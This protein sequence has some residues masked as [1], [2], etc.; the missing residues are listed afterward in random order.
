VEERPV[1][2]LISVYDKRDL[3]HLARGLGEI[4]AEIIATLEGTNYRLD[5]VNG[6]TLLIKGALV[7]FALAL[8]LG[9]RMLALRANPGIRTR[10]LR[11]LT[12]WELAA[13]VAVLVAVGVLVNSAP[14][15]SSAQV[16]SSSLT[17]GPAPLS[18]PTLQLGGLFGLG[19]IVGVSASSDELRFTILKIDE[20]APRGTR[21]R[22]EVLAPRSAELFPRPCGAGGFQIHYPLSPCPVPLVVSVAVPHWPSELRPA[23]GIAGTGG[24]F[25]KPEDFSVT[26]L[27][28]ANH[29]QADAGARAE[30]GRRSDE[31]RQR[32]LGIDRAA[33]VEHHPFLA[34]R[35]AV[36][37]MSATAHALAG[38]GVG[39]GDTVISWLPNGPQALR[40]WFGCGQLGAVFVPVNT[41]YKGRLE[42]HGMR[43]IA[44]G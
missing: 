14:P 37:A 31:G 27:D 28:R 10:L 7:A 11:R 44:E 17:L 42:Q 29:G 19:N 20:P 40:T 25:L 26:A 22:V 21:M 2:V 34:H 32:S 4:G 6:R 36:D 39:R 13:L 3:E 8:A 33:T 15:R 9:S 16:R 24:Q 43:R 38:L 18:G 23:P 30:P 35:D 5:Y 12:R 41:A 1:R